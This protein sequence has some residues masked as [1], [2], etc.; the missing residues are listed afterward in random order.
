MF[1]PKSGLL[2]ACQV[3]GRQDVSGNGGR[4]CV[5]LAGSG[6]NRLC[7]MIAGLLLCIFMKSP[8]GQPAQRSIDDAVL[9][10][11]GML[12][13]DR[14]SLA[15]A[16][17]DKIVSPPARLALV[18]A[19]IQDPVRMA[20]LSRGLVNL[21]SERI[22]GGYVAGII[23]LL[24]VPGIATRAGELTLPDHQ[25]EFSSLGIPPPVIEILIQVMHAR[26][27]MQ[28]IHW[29]ESEQPG[30]LGQYI[31]KAITTRDPM[32][33]SRLIVPDMYMDQG[34]GFDAGRVT[35]AL[36]TL[37]S[38]LETRLPELR[39]KLDQR[40]TG[41]WE[42]PYGRVGISGSSDD[43]HTGP[44][45]LLIDLG[46][47]DS[48]RNVASLAETGSVSI[49]IDL[50]G[51]DDVGWESSAGPGSGVF[52]LG[53]WIDSEGNDHYEGRNIG[54]GA[55]VFGAGL[56][57]DKSGD[58]VYISGSL[59]QG[60]GQY[61]TGI[62][63]DEAGNDQYVA[64]V[65]SQGFGGPR[66]YGIQIDLG[67]NDSYQ[68]GGVIPD[69]H[70]ERVR[71]HADSH[72]FS[73]C[74]GYGFG[75][76]PVVSGGIGVLLDRGGNDQYVADMFAQ[77][78][79]TWFGFGILTD[80]AG[81]DSYR[82]FEHCQG[83]GLH[84]GAGFLGDW[85]GN[86]SYEGYEHCQGTGV[87]ASA[88]FLVDA[89]GDD[90]YHVNRESQGAGVKPAGI[91]L[92]VDANGNDVYEASTDAQGYA[93]ALENLP[94]SMRPIGLMLDMGGNDH[95]RYPGFEAPTGKGRFQNDRGL[96]IDY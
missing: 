12:G 81:D 89:Q 80:V 86:D 36:I 47:N 26:S 54:M 56:L 77:G 93:A 29:P 35:G 63:L 76:R 95:Y 61:G 60:A 16:G 34:A 42:T 32:I 83:E 82:A 92:F 73:L 27:I 43:R 79:A 70:A 30:P 23:D 85:A 71:R 33:T 69:S 10:A 1:T 67:G 64:E 68:C 11:A 57:W 37:A 59:S 41:E 17:L 50:A 44:W 91:G 20:D 38:Y 84:A 14:R 53:I 49:V 66:G 19:V 74:Q 52:G 21:G 8:A 9:H 31:A 45:L 96:A 90:T 87:D 39:M 65:A 6:R 3:A 48:Y 75:M 5:S 13:L 28:E 88:G 51:D 15:I 18:D 78:A 7:I 40:D 62:L 55:G 94:L 25:D 46:G 72:F 4:Q 2:P 22:V 24:E 58:D